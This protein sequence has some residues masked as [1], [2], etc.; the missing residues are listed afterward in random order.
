MKKKYSKN[1]KIKLKAFELANKSFHFTSDRNALH[2]LNQNLVVISGESRSGKTYLIKNIIKSLDN[3]NCYAIEPPS[4][5]FKEPLI[6]EVSKLFA[7][8]L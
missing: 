2:L 1:K 4:H 5:F 8:R 6:D 3:K 7:D